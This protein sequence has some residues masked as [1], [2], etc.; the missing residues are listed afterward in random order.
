[1]KLNADMVNEI[2]QVLEFIAQYIIPIAAFVVS[3]ISLH[4]TRKISELEKKI[5]EYDAF[6]KENEVQKILEEKSKKP[7][8][9]IDARV[10]TISKNQHRIYVYNKGTANAYNI[11]YKLDKGSCIIPINPVTPFEVLE[12]GGHFEEPVA[13]VMSGS[14]PKYK[15]TLYWEDGDGNKKQKD[16]VKSIE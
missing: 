7:E 15:I 16:M 2:K 11:D 4:K 10:T 5:T 12:P 8:A 13:V 1:M 9:Q 6:I 14:G 3:L